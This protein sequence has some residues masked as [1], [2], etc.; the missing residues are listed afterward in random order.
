[1]VDIVMRLALDNT[2]WVVD[3]ASGSA[4]LF[5]VTEL[6]NFHGVKTWLEAGELSTQ[7]NEIVNFLCEFDTSRWLRVSEEVELAWGS[8]SLG[9]GGLSEVVGIDGLGGVGD[10]ISGTMS[11]ASHPGN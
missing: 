11:T 8:D 9:L 10:K 1:M 7:W 4:T 6:V 3:L 5:Q 2:E